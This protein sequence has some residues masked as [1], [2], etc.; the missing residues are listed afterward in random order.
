MMLDTHIA[1]IYGSYFC[2]FYY[3][4]EMLKSPSYSL[5]VSALKGLSVQLTARGRSCPKSIVTISVDMVRLPPTFPLSL[6]CVSAY[7]REA[8]QQGEATSFLCRI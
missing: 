6:Q 7:V 3:C 1:I 8:H 4:A 5:G 2:G